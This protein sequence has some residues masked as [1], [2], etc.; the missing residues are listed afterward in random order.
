MS[1]PL[2]VFVVGAMLL[3]LL[4]LGLIVGA[5]L[6]MNVIEGFRVV[7]STTWGLATL[8]DVYAGLALAAVL[9]A[10]LERSPGR[11]AAWAAAIL[12]LGNLATVA[13]I[14]WRASRVRTLT[15]F[16]T[17]GPARPAGGSGRAA[18]SAPGAS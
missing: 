6:E 3:G 1:T 18:R 17:P 13:Y 2:R 10:V 12:V 4:L 11:G 5:S 15:G 8:V 14:V 7:G 9:V 16:F